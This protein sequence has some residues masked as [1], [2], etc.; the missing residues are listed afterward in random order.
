MRRRF[1]LLALLTL[2]LAGCAV[3]D[4]ARYDAALSRWQVRPVGHYL[5]R[6]YDELGGHRCGQ[7]VEV[8]DETLERVVS[9]TCAHP[10]LW[11]VDWLFRHVARS[12][13]DDRRCSK[14]VAGIGCICHAASQVQVEYDAALGYPRE[15]T[16][17]ETWRAAW[18]EIGYWRYVVQSGQLPSCAVPAAGPQWR[19]VVREL[20]PLP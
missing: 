5:L 14:L 6:T 8:R 12:R 4:S 3:G 2:V 17:W 11:T 9:N 10:N 19:V 15:I 13:Q 16:T 7:A 20:R 1:A 18:W